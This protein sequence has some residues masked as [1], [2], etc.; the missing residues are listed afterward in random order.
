MLPSLVAVPSHTLID[1]KL[2]KRVTVKDY[3]AYDSA[4]FAEP[5]GN[6][7]KSH[8]TAKMVSSGW[9]PKPIRHHSQDT[10]PKGSVSNPCLV[11]SATAE[12]LHILQTMCLLFIRI[13]V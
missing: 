11:G 4:I 12:T 9:S 2:L 3:D 13:T 1:D 10:P 8:S 7:G 6:V 5:S